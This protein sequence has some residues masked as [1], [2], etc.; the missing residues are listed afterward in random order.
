M[1][2]FLTIALAFVLVLG[3]CACTQDA[4]N[5][6]TTPSQNNTPSNTPLGYTFT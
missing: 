5:N 1:K 4:S 2:K 6:P 3:L